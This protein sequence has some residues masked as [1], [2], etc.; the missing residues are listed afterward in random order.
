MITYHTEAGSPVVEIGVAG[1]VTNYD[2][3]GWL[4]HLRVDL[5]E[6]GKSRILEIIEQFSS[7]EPAAIWTDIKLGIPLANKVDRVAVVADQAWIRALSK[8]GELFTRAEVRSFEPN[9]LDEVR[10]WIGS[11]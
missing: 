7:I 2:L 9:E 3:E 10:A 8:L 4:N 5:D 11:A 1:D 6:N